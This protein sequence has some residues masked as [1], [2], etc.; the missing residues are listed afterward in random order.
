MLPDYDYVPVET[1]LPGQL[2]HD[3]DPRKFAD[4]HIPEFH[5][6]IRCEIEQEIRPM[7]ADSSKEVFEYA[8]TVVQRMVLEA[9]VESQ[10][11]SPVPSVP[12]MDLQPHSLHGGYYAGTFGVT[13]LD[14][15]ISTADPLDGSDQTGD[16]YF[17]EYGDGMSFEH[18]MTGTTG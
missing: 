6:R 1:T 15:D 10:K 16:A 5:T 2:S 7:L 9:L 11:R 17:S 4:F 18:H 13:N 14:Y 8:V 3:L 12:A